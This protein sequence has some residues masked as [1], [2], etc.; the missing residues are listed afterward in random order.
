[1]KAYKY[2]NEIILLNNAQKIDCYDTGSGAKSNPHNYIV[3]VF[4]GA[5]D[6]QTLHL[7]KISEEEKDFVLNE[8]FNIIIAQ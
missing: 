3:R 5:N 1:M 8:I 2:Q 7:G 6:Y 4:F